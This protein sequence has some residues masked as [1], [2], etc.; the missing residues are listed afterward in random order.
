LARVFYAPHSRS[1]RHPAAP[2]RSR[3]RPPDGPR[4]ETGTRRF[5]FRRQ[6]PPRLQYGNISM[7]CL[8]TCQYTR[9]RKFGI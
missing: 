4:S 9:E 6:Q 5:R 7:F 8:P 3:S 2:P 1:N